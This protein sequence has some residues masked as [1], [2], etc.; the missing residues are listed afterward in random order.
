M[1][2]DFL[3]NRFHPPS[4]LLHR[5]NCIFKLVLWVGLWWNQ[6]GVVV[7]STNTHPLHTRFAYIIMFLCFP[8]YWVQLQEH[9]NPRHPPPPPPLSYISGFLHSQP[10]H[11]RRCWYRCKYGGPSY[12]Q[13]YYLPPS[14]IFFPPPLYVTLFLP[15]LFFLKSGSSFYCTGGLGTQIFVGLNFPL[16]TPPAPKGSKPLYLTFPVHVCLWNPTASGFVSPTNVPPCTTTPMWRGRME[17]P[18]LYHHLSYHLSVLFPLTL[19]LGWVHL[20]VLL[21]QSIDP[22]NTP[23]GSSDPLEG[24]SPPSLPVYMVSPPVTSF[25]PGDNLSSWQAHGYIPWATLYSQTT[26]SLCWGNLYH[27]CLMVLVEIPSPLIGPT[28]TYAP[29][30]FCIPIM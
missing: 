7:L 8:P 5:I 15:P 28:V 26:P 18:P 30:H 24:A 2:Y 22:L 29:C 27:T 10:T 21:S 3:P 20:V 4:N 6:V 12:S 25:I 1:L 11:R 23:Y 9:P 16:V 19:Y 14:S 17:G 13:A